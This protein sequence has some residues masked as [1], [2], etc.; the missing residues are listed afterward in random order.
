MTESISLS[1]KAAFL[2]AKA[3]AASHS[4]IMATPAFQHAAMLALAEY[5]YRLSN[6]DSLAL[7]GAK[8]KGAQEFLGVLL[9][10]GLPEGRSHAL[11][12]FALVPPE[13]ALRNPQPV[14]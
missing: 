8:L 9:N 7:A 10:L 5:T 2:A 12:D 13:E 1:P 3:T 14:K 6:P 4:D 11:P